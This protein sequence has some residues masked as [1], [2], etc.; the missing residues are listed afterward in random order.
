[1]IWAAAQY[2]EGKAAAPLPLRYALQARAYNALPDAGGLRDQ[3]A[4]LINQMSACY[5]VYAAWRSFHTAPDKVDWKRNNPDGW[6]IVK[7]VLKLGKH[8]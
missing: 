6:D 4:K 2:A 5:N 8:D 1:M 7:E 3:P